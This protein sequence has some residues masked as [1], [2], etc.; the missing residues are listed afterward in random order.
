MSLTTVQIPAIAK[1]TATVVFM[2]G[3]GDSGH[4]WYPVGEM[5]A[6]RLPHIKWI[7]PNAPNQ[8]VT[9]NGGAKM[10][11]WYDIV[12][13]NAFAKEDKV[14]LLASSKCITDLISNE[15]KGGIPA[16]RIVL[17]GFSQG[18]VVALLGGLTS[19][20]TYAGLVALSGYLALRT[21]IQQLK[22]TANDSTPIF[23]GHG[24]EDEVVNYEYGKMSSEFLKTELHANVDFKTYRGIGHSTHPKELEDLTAFLG[25][26]LPTI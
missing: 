21:E 1:H 25:K 13:L 12:A 7:F 23:M 15:V 11:S 6:P 20:S 19:N 26:V 24:Y 9:L 14:G 3:L 2:H 16:D 10:P 17:G 4:G 8:P 5:L 18:A 22:T